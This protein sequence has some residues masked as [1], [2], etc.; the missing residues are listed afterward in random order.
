MRP[1]LI[2][3]VI[4][5]LALALGG[6]TMQPDSRLDEYQVEAERIMADAVALIPEDLRTDVVVSESEPRFGP[7]EGAASPDQPAWWQVSE[8]LQQ[9]DETDAS[10]DAAAEISEGLAA[11][12]WEQ[13]RVRETEQGARITD[14]FR[15]DID[16]EQW[17]IEVTSVT[18]RP[19]K[20]EVVQLLVVSPTTVRGDNDAPS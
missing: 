10:A 16:G 15:R 8:I 11:D 7:I 20:A 2:A 13:S 6:C 17:Y 18:T 5:V 9:V 3:A 1:T 12:G 4:A 19:D 14:G